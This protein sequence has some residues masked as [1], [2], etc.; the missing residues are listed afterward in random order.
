MLVERNVKIEGNGSVRRGTALNVFFC[1]C[2][3]SQISVAKNCFLCL[4]AKSIQHQKSSDLGERRDAFACFA[5]SEG[6]MREVHINGSVVPVFD[7]K[8]RAKV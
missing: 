7:A 6:R 5:S 2:R 4:A 3:I 1:S 8:K